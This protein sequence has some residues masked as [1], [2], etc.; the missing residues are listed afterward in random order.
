M[1]IAGFRIPNRE[2]DRAILLKLAK[3]VLEHG[4]F[5]SNY[6]AEDLVDMKDPELVLSREQQEILD[7]INK[8]IDVLLENKKT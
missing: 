8:L 3:D 7:Q 4:D 5:P 2:A 6:T 1:G